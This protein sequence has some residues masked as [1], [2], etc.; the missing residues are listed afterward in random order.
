MIW[1]KENWKKSGWVI[2][3]DPRRHGSPYDRGSSDAYYG[4][5]PEPHFWLDP[6]GRKTVKKSKM[7][8]RQI[9]EYYKGYEEEDDRKE[10]E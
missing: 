4:R 5:A 7:T 10:W 1:E 3:T 9:E 6:L 2:L 8:D